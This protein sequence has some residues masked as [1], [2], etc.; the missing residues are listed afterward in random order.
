M[1]FSNIIQNV[2]SGKAI[3][4]AQNVGIRLTP[5]YVDD[6]I[7][8]IKSILG[9]RIS[10]PN[11]I[12]NICGDEIITLNQIVRIVEKC[13]NKKANINVTSELPK[14]FI[15]TNHLLKELIEDVRFESVEQGLLKTIKK[16][17]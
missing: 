1:L 3:S 12:I 16:H 5:I 4:L 7:W 2:K 13:L 11:H 6:L 14:N 8:I 15:G 17:L 9:K 10:A